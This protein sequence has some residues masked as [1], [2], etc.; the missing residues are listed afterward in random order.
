[1]LSL[2]IKKVWYI[3]LPKKK[4]TNNNNSKSEQIEIAKCPHILSF[5]FGGQRVN[6]LVGLGGS[7]I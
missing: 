5:R 1:M 2:I 4:K 3:A 7:N 6:S